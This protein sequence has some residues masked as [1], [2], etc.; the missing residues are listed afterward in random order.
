MR[1]DRRTHRGRPT[2][3]ARGNSQSYSQSN[4]YPCSRLESRTAGGCTPSRHP[5]H[6]STADVTAQ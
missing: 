2:G 6:Q 4:S 3:A 1:S 5:Q